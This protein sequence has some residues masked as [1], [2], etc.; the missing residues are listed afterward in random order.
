MNEYEYTRIGLN[1]V[2]DEFDWIEHAYIQEKVYKKL[3]RLDQLKHL[4]ISYVQ[5]GNSTFLSSY[6][7]ELSYIF[8]NQEDL[9]LIERR[10]QAYQAKRDENRE[11]YDV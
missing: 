2:A 11:V 8:D 6:Q 9:E 1:P 10:R 5:T 7:A 4:L 3:D